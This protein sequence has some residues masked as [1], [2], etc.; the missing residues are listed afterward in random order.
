[1]PSKSN[2]TFHDVSYL[3]YQFDMQLMPRV[4][5]QWAFVASSN[6]LMR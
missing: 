2:Q 4:I 3:R 1:M 5:P 6:L